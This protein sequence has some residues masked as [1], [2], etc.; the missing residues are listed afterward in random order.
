M[1]RLWM[2]AVW[3]T[4]ALCV[5][6]TWP[7]Y[8]AGNGLVPG[9]FAFGALGAWFAGCAAHAVAPRPALLRAIGAGLVPLLGFAAAR[10]ATVSPGKYA[11]DGRLGARPPWLAS[12]IREEESA[13]AGVVLVRVTGVLAP[14]EM[15][16]I[17]AMIAERYRSV[18]PDGVNAVLLT[19]SAD[20]VRGIVD[21][22]AGD[23][24]FPAVLFLHGY[25]GLLTAY[26]GAL[27]EEPRLAGYAIVAPALDVNGE[28]WTPEGLAV[29]GR[30]LDTL[31][32]AVDRSRVWLVGLSNGAVGAMAVA[33]D[34]LGGRFRGIVALEGGGVRERVGEVRVPVHLIAA[35]EDPRFSLG[36]VEMVAEELGPLGSL[37]VI[38][39]DHLA[40][41]THRPAATAAVADAV[42]A[43]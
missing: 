11:E 40:F 3:C 5:A 9:A 34:D 42:G 23:G 33:A 2:I 28:W 22:P 17:D 4:L 16:H 38:P 19:S 43:P 32:P 39:G 13:R 20:R 1:C 37:T 29:V 14:D 10:V 7:M 18:D 8:V 24:P 21:L 25:G 27:R 35:R 12:V 31:P 26:I 41:F 15:P 36:Y 6:L 30:A